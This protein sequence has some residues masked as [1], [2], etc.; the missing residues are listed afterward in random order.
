MTRICEQCNNELRGKQ[1]RFCSTKCRNDS[2]RLSDIVLK[3]EQCGGQFARKPAEL[4]RP[5]R[6]N[7]FCS[8]RCARAAQLGTISLK[9][10]RRITK[11]CPVCK[12]TFETG[13][14]SGKKL[15]VFCSREC[16]KAARYR[17][18]TECK[19]L[20]I[21]DAA[22]IAGFLDGE[23]SIMVLKRAKSISIRVTAANCVDSVLHWLTEITGVGAV[24]GKTHSVNP[25]ARPSFQFVCNASGAHTLLLQVKSFLRIKVE[26]ANL[27][28]EAYERTKDPATKTDYTW[29]DDFVAK[30]KELNKRGN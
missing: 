6:P 1:K 30:S 13:G 8:V 25:N 14:R 17:R 23:G 21:A 5:G 18:G 22:Y 4:N 20:S 12:N 16:A 3:C 7:K 29:Q 24:I 2:A 10:R 26:Q 15:A 11:I 28:I 27:A 19:N 9:R